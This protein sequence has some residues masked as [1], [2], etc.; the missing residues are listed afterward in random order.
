MVVLK[1]WIVSSTALCTSNATLFR[2]SSF[3]TQLI[4]Y[5]AV[6]SLPWQQLPEVLLALLVYFSAVQ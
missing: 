5:L 1:N 2:R 3:K 4:S 6:I